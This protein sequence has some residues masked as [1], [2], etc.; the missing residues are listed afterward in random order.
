M[1]EGFAR[2]AHEYDLPNVVLYNT[3]G[4]LAEAHVQARVAMALAE[5]WA[6]KELRLDRSNA[7]RSRLLAVAEWVFFT[8]VVVLAGFTVINIGR[9]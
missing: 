5:S 3:P 2:R 6:P 9:R 1:R 8:N 7:L 4:V